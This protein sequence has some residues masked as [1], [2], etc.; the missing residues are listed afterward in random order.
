M[1][2]LI[3]MQRPLVTFSFKLMFKV[4][5]YFS[6]SCG[7]ELL[8]L[9]KD[10]KRNE[11]FNAFVFENSPSVYMKEYCYYT[12]FALKVVL[13][14]RNILPFKPLLNLFFLNINNFFKIIFFSS[15][16]MSSTYSTCSKLF[17]FLYL[18]T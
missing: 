11:R 12:M 10:M 18:L 16:F 14:F 5:G 4:R 3:T 6:Y 15:L 8:H 2:L 1:T 13:I 9:D 7:S 17:C